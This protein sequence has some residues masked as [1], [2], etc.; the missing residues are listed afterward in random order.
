MSAIYASALYADSDETEWI[1]DTAAT[2]HFCNK[3][4]LFQNYK[5]LKNKSATLGEGNT[6]ICGIGNAVLEIDRNGEKSRLILLNDLH[7][8]HMRRNLISG[9]LIDKA[10]LTAV[11]RNKKINVN[12][13]SGDEMF[14]AYL[15][16]NFYVLQAKVLKSSSSN[17]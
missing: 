3:K 4:E 7:A 14:I 6:V 1:I 13:P 10:G 2:D 12:Y 16:N 5:E 17:L 11:R 8:P 9:R 15:K